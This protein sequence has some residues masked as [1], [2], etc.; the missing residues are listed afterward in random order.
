MEANLKIMLSTYC[1]NLM[2][3]YVMTTWYLNSD[4]WL[5][6][7]SYHSEYYV[8]LNVLRTPNCLWI[9]LFFNYE[10]GVSDYFSKNLT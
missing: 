2:N 5:P 4:G 8:N 10:L 3:I 1:S 6:V 9:I 7:F